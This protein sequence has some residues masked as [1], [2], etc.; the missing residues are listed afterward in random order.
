MSMPHYKV[1]SHSEPVSGAVSMPGSKSYTNRYLLL[2]ALCD[3]ESVLRN[4]SLSDDSAKMIEILSSLGVKIDVE[5]E[6]VHVTGLG[7]A[8]APYKGVFNVGPA[9]TCFRFMTAMLAALPGMDVLLQGSARMNRRPVQDLA[10]AINKLGGDIEYVMTDAHPPLQIIGKQLEREEVTLPGEISSQ[11]LSALLMI[12]PLIDGGLAINVEGEQVSK[13]YV[14]M[15]IDCMQRYGVAVAREGYSRF[16]VVSD[17][18]YCARE[19]QVEGDASGASYFWAIAALTGGT[20]RVQ[21][22]SA[23]SMQGDVE[24]PNLLD[25]MGCTVQS[26][27]QA[28]VP[29]IEVTGAAESLSSISADMSSMP[30]TAQTLAVVAA[31]ANGPTVLTGLSTLKDKETDRLKALEVEL[32]KLGIGVTATEDSIAIEGGAPSAGR[33]STYSDHRM[34]MSFAALATAVPGIEIENPQVVSK[35][36]LLYT[37][38]SPRDPL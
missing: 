27:E 21:N 10:T 17:A 33:I 36:C 9:G 12:G 5:S 16:E 4:A 32:T 11:F 1:T 19:V 8:F 22:V 14:D 34:A 35:S 6:L 7:P 30:D 29:W 3:G 26:G 38:P 28:G 13:S 23:S 37:S 20:V 25:R 31:C 24:F 18:R 15:T 2:S